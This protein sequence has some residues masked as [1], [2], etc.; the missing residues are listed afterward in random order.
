MVALAVLTLFVVAVAMTMALGHALELPGKMRLPREHYVAAQTIYY[1][2]YTLG[3]IS[4]PLGFLLLVILAALTPAGS[5]PFWL[6]AGAAA[7]I[8]AM[9]AVF[10]L[11]TQPVNRYWLKDIK[12]A[13]AGRGFFATGAAPHMD[14]A[15][16][17]ELRDRWELSHVIRAGLACLALVLVA[18]AIALPAGA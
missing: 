13:A 3:G 8:A 10:W 14:N 1:P 12:L 18:T 15:N 17:T 5:Q 4:E 16:W 11:M 9:H 7:S 2:G 6:I